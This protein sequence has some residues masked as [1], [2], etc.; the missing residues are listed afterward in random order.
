M[1]TG[2]A[3]DFDLNTVTEDT[4]LYAKWTQNTYTVTFDLNYTGATGTA[5]AHPAVMYEG[6]ITAPTTEPQR[7]GW[8]FGG[9]FLD[10][11][12]TGAAWNFVTGTVTENINLYAKWTQIKYTVTFNTGAGG[13]LVPALEVPHGST[14]TRPGTNPTRANH[15]FDN[16]YTA[17]ADT[18]YN[19]NS[20]VTADI[21]LYAKWM[22]LTFAVLL[23]DM[24]ADAAA[25]TSAKTYILPSGDETYNG[26]PALNSATC[27]ANVV[28]DGGN[29]VVTAARTES[30][31]ARALQL[32]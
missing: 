31:L 22:P 5:P 30:R 24:A 11:A 23:A 16:W 14:T 6:N 29:R 12:G 7:T 9:W 32:R 1:R 17:N 15:D 18:P 27:P 3:W 10:A 13:S 2:A 4:T 19:F 28:V 20:P 25:N 21:T 8:T 26:S